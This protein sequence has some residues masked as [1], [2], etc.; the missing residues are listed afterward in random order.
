[1]GR[2]HSWVIKELSRQ[3]YDVTALV[4]SHDTFIHFPEHGTKQYKY[5]FDD[6]SINIY[7]YSKDVKI[8]T[9]QIYEYIK[10]LKP[11]II[12]TIGPVEELF[13]IEA[14]CTF[15]GDEFKWISI[16]ANNSYGIGKEFHSTI[17]KMSGCLCTNKHTYVTLKYEINF[18]EVDYCYVGCDTTIFNSPLENKEIKIMSRCMNNFKDNVYDTTKLIKF[19]PNSYL[20]IPTCA[21]FYDLSSILNWMN[22]P[23]SPITLSSGVS[24]IEYAEKLREHDL[25][26]TLSYC[27]S[28]SMS[29]FEA[30]ACGSVIIYPLSLCD[31]EVV[32]FLELPVL[33]KSGIKTQELMLNNGKILHNPIYDD[34]ANVV[35][36]LTKMDKKYINEYKDKCVENIDKLSNR[37][38]LNKVLE[39]LKEISVKKKIINLS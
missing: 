3:N 35:G 28:T 26:L 29:L 32:N 7:L 1:M 37:N 30:A 25:F 34:A 10:A 11:D 36:S 22:V 12:V 18:N 16:L 6:D 27:S 31:L 33:K 39:L 2:L 13:F 21:G 24:D 8:A 23:S 15:H 17:R 5:K 9:V 20:H 14:L 38:F 4:N 19:Y